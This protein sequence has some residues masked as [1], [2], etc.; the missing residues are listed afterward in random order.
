[1]QTPGC[2]YVPNAFFLSVLLF[3]GTFLLS[4]HFKKFRTQNFFPSTVRN[5]ISDFAV[6]I[7]ITSMTL[8]DFLMVSPSRQTFFLRRRRSDEIGQSV[9]PR[10][11]Y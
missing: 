1:M 7:A 8:T 5:F 11:S 10:K 3:L 9:F 6:V 4:Y 2:N